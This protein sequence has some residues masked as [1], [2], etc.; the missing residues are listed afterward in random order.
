[1]TL[2][3]S[4]YHQRKSNNTLKVLLFVLLSLFNKWAGILT[5]YPSAS[6]FNYALGPPNP[7]LIDIAKETLSF[8]RAPISDALWLLM[9]TFL[10][11]SAP[12]I[13]TNGLHCTTNTPLPR[14]HNKIMHSVLSSVLNL[15]P[16]KFSAHSFLLNT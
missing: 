2:G 14:A 9:P 7:W 6:S 1:M 4:L 11:R 15:S 8:W 13:L 10:L 12:P 3:W 5:G 16:D